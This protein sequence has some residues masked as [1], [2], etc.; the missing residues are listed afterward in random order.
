MA[1]FRNHYDCDR[2]G[3]SWT[4]E[5][6]CTC[7]DDCPYCGARHMSVLGSEDLTERVVIDEGLV[8]FLVSPP[9]AEYHPDYRVVAAFPL[10]GPGG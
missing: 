7:D 1:W 2:C 3:Q 6:S 10:G 4:D 5:W 8:A 9:T